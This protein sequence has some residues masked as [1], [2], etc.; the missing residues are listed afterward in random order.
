VR[1]HDLRR[2][3]TVEELYL[4]SSYANFSVRDGDP[5]SVAALLRDGGRQALVTSPNQHFPYC[6]VFDRDA[7]SLALEPIDWV[8]RRVSTDRGP[9][10]AIVNRHSDELSYRLYDRG[11]LV[12]SYSSTS[13][14][15]YANYNLDAPGGDTGLLCRTLGCLE[16][17][18]R[19]EATL[20]GYYLYAD[21]QHCSL[22]AALGLHMYSV[23]CGYADVVRMGGV[24]P[25]FP[26]ERQLW[27]GPS[28]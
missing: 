3:K 21:H 28:T 26:Y 1:W 22:A 5:D 24:R 9:V 25:P 19:V 13:N 17:V 20:R 4:G 10:L 16:D 14:R 15:F 12:D 23:G 7:D 8:G 2:A 18:E 6:A 27:V 11:Q